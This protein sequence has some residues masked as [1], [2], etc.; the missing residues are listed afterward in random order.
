VPRLIALVPAAGSGA[1]FGAHTLKQYAPVLGRPLL[2]HALRALHSYTAIERIH[3]LLS[4]ADTQ[5]RTHDWSDFGARA[6]PLYCGGET[7]AETVANALQLLA[8]EAKPNDWIL[9]HDAARP[10]LTAALLQRLIAQLSDDD[11]GGLLALPLTDTLKRADGWQRVESTEPRERLWRAQTP[12]MFRYGVLQRA[13]AAA[14]AGVPTDESWAVEKLGL[15]PRLVHGDLINFKVTFP[16]DVAVAEQLLRAIETN[17]H[18]S[19]L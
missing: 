9:V 16:D 11:V 13:L 14:P 4:P 3:P 17:A 1:R 8:A 19:G 5:W 6:Q 10:C 18:R 15:H 2:Y 12:Q 7:R